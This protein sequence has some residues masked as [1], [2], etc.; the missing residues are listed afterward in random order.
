LIPN[1]INFLYQPGKSIRLFLRF[2]AKFE[3]IFSE[4]KKWLNEQTAPVNLPFL[5]K[6]MLDNL[7][8]APRKFGGLIIRP[9][10]DRPS[11]HLPTG[12]DK[13][14][15]QNRKRRVFRMKISIF[16]LALVLQLSQFRRSLN[17]LNLPA[18]ESAR[19]QF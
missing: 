19:R 16:P 6:P 15:T 5:H 12:S 10:V 18:P 2:R 11:V 14:K 1:S 9:G 7:F 3:G 13:L 8:Q 17:L 4:R